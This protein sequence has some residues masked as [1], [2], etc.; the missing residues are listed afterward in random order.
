MATKEQALARSPLHDLH[1]RLGATFVGADGWELP[2]VFSDVEAEYHA[3][4]EKAALVDRSAVGRLRATGPDTLDLLNRLSTNQTDPLAPGC[5][6]ATVLTTNKGRI[7]DWLTVL[8][9]DGSVLILTA[10][11][12][13]DA[14]AEWI[15]RYTIVEDVTLEDVTTETA[16]LCAMGP[17]SVSVVGRA[18]GLSVDRLALFDCLTVP[19]QGQ[20]ILVT[21]TDPV[22]LPGYDLMAPSAVAQKLWEGLMEAGKPELI[23]PI[24]QQTMEALRIE[25]GIP[26]WGTELSEAYNPLEAGLTS[27]ISWTKG[28]YIGQEV[29][30]RLWTYHKVQKY[31]VGISFEGEGS[32]EAGTPLEIEGQNV[33]TLT[34]VAHNPGAGK[35]LGLGYLRA[36]HAREGAALEVALEGGGRLTGDVVRVPEM[37]TEPVPATLLG[38]DEKEE[39][40]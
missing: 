37:P 9:P 28:C 22:G 24:G 5:G 30:A 20:E 15:D 29:V 17:A 25:Q 39:E 14:V 35:T 12:A 18:L 40:A 4:R 31:L 10:P 11:Q 32:A 16:L 34:S 21:R 36:A 2:G 13:R 33:G 1:R 7:I 19:W 26:R 8:H 3:A 6:V 27:S 23:Q 38:V